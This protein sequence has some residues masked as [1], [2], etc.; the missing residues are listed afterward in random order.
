[1]ALFIRL[2]IDYNGGLGYPSYNEPKY[3]VL[4]LI[5]FLGQVIGSERIFEKWNIQIYR[6]CGCV[7][8]LAKAKKTI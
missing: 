6:I 5:E 7:I 8:A 4:F 3:L 2:Y 1:V